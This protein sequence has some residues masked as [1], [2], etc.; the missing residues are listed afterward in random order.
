MDEVQLDSA[1]ILLLLPLMETMDHLQ[2]FLL[3]SVGGG[4]DI[5]SSH[6]RMDLC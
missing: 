2:Y 3:L 6:L 4:G 1:Q 5:G